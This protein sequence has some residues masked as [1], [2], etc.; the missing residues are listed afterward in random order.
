MPVRLLLHGVEVAVC[1][2][3]YDKVMVLLKVAG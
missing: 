2:L 3:I 1:L